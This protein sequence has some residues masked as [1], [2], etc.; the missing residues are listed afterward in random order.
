ML[1]DEDARNRLERSLSLESIVL[2]ALLFFVHDPERRE[3]VH[4]GEIAKI[5]N[6][7]RMGRGA[8]HKLDPRKIGHVLR[9]L[10]FRTQ[11]VDS[12]GRGV[13]LV[14]KVRRAVHRLA[15]AWEAP[16]VRNDVAQCE[17]CQEF[18][19]QKNASSSKR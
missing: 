13:L 1:A 3:A 12:A 18:R 2:D 19:E 5:V 10:D 16:S 15:W 8:T 17:I 11:D 7:I 4:V 6:E 14:E 9:S